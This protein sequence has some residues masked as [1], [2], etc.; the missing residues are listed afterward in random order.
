MLNFVLQVLSQLPDLC[1]TLVH[2]SA[3]VRHMSAR[4][5]AALSLLDTE[6]VMEV[7]VKSVLPLLAATGCD[8]KRQGAAECIACVVEKLQFAIIPYVVLLVIPLL[9]NN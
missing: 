5:I 2:E 1:K 7:I 4:C 8:A 3:A 9:G 6:Q